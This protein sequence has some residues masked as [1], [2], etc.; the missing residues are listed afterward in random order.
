M[1]RRSFVKGSLISGAATAIAPAIAMAQPDK[2][3]YVEHYELRVYTFKDERQQKITEDFFRD[4]YVPM[5]KK[6]IYEPVGVFTELYP[7]GQTKLYVLVPYNT[8]VHWEGLNFRLETDKEYWAKGAAFL[9]APASDPAFERMDTSLMKAFMHMRMK[10]LPPRE[11]RIF[12]LR[13]YKSASEAAGKKK[14]E[15]FNDKGEIDIFKRLGFKPVFFGETIFGNDRPNLTYMVTFK[16]MEDKAAHWKAFG[17]DPEWK[18]I[19]AVPEYADA[20]LVSKITST[21]LVPTSYSGI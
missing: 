10:Q 4:V 6:Q 17:S 9:N 13:Q 16:D 21:M 20:L 11:Q 3:P 18:K 14:I 19:S 12:E 1:K 5:V 15:M 7:T 8:Y 2:P